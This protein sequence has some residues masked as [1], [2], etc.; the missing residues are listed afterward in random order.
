[1]C[2]SAQDCVRPAG[3]PIHAPTRSPTRGAGHSCAPR[4]LATSSGLAFAASTPHT[5]LDRV[6][7]RA[8]SLPFAAGFAQF[9][10]KDTDR[11]TPDRSHPRAAG[12]RTFVVVDLPGNQLGPGW[13]RRAG[14][15]LADGQF[16]ASVPG[17]PT[18]L[19]MA[20]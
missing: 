11:S 17:M 13:R 4:V 14:E 20:W 16:R 15:P 6:S 3:A 9:L 18:V 10:E 1:M 7:K 8:D 12:N 5:H 19:P 2:R